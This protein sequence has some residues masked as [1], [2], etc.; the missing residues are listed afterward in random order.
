MDL[1]YRH[2]SGGELWQGGIEDVEALIAA[3][4]SSIRVIALTAMHVQPDTVPRHYKVIRAGLIDEPNL[5]Y[6]AVRLATAIADIVSGDLAGYVSRGT[7]VLSSCRAGRNRSGL[8]SALVLMKLAGK[9]PAEAVEIVRSSR[10]APD[11]MAL[12][13]PLFVKI[14]HSLR[15]RVGSHHQK[16]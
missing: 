13:N 14:L 2:P 6:E 7:S 16:P 5:D 9:S 8:V 12:T 4:H 1:I 3:K 10:K 11:G 15:A